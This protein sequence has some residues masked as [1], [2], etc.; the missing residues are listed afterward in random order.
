MCPGSKT[1]SATWDTNAREMTDIFK[2][3]LEQRNIPYITVRGDFQ[4]REA[5]VRHA[6][7]SLL[8][9]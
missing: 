5:T 8:K 7:E 6:I 4:Q 1:A 9:D 2:S 3:A